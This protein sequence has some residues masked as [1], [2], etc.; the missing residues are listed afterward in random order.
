MD[1]TNPARIA[2][3]RASP[4]S[5]SFYIDTTTGKNLVRRINLVGVDKPPTFDGPGPT[6]ASGSST[7]P[8]THSSSIPPES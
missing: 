3:D 2:Y 5:N 1:S 4:T 6:A 7:S 8:P